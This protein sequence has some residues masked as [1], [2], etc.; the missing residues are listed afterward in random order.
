MDHKNGMEMGMFLA[1]LI[2]A[3]VPVLVGIGFYV[4]YFRE[5]RAEKRAALETGDQP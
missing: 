3:I 2:M 1:G 4:F 5:Y